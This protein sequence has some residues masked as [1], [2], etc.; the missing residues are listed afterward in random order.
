MSWVPAVLSFFQSGCRFP[1]GKTC[2]LYANISLSRNLSLSFTACS[3]E[4][5]QQVESLTLS[6]LTNPSSAFISYSPWDLRWVTALCWVSVSF[7]IKWE[8]KALV[9]WI[10]L[11][12]ESPR[13][14]CLTV[15]SFVVFRT[16][17]TVPRVCHLVPSPGFCCWVSPLN[18]QRAQYH[19][20]RPG[21]ESWVQILLS[22]VSV[23]V[24]LSRPLRLSL[25]LFFL[26]LFFR[27]GITM[28]ADT[29]TVKWDKPSG[30]MWHKE[31][32]SREWLPSLIPHPAL[33]RNRLF[34]I[35][36]FSR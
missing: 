13:I 23:L 26:L 20:R 14:C 7:I 32:S 10:P 16:S 6:R 24:V 15:G 21:P 29:V 36:R 25:S 1:V 34:Q 3:C 5:R 30:N 17:L 9:S 27:I 11:C 22:G 35:N 28:C 8:H 33:L 31:V 4:Q 2:V 18:V 19:W 12:P